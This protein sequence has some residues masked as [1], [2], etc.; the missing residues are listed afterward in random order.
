M[1]ISICI[2]KIPLKFIDQHPKRL[3]IHLLAFLIFVILHIAFWLLKIVMKECSKKRYNQFQSYRSKWK[4]VFNTKVIHFQIIQVVGSTYM[5]VVFS[6]GVNF[7]SLHPTEVEAFPN[8]VL[9]FLE[10]NVSS[11]VYIVVIIALLLKKSKKLRKE[12]WHELKN[13]FNVYV[14]S[15]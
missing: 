15:K 3:Y 13:M 12:V 7:N 6:F 10:N 14:V 9:F 8:Y 1:G 11:P 4:N 2:G 5:M